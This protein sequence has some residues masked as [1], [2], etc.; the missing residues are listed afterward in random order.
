MNPSKRTDD[1]RT[2][3]GVVLPYTPGRRY[4]QSTNEYLT[5]QSWIITPRDIT[6]LVR[7]RRSS[8][9]VTLLPGDENFDIVRNLK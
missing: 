1:Y 2:R 3:A 5:A 4:T 8:E 9:P 6:T 7:S